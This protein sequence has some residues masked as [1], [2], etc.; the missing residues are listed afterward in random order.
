[1]ISLAPARCNSSLLPRRSICIRV[2]SRW[3]SEGVINFNPLDSRHDYVGP[4]WCS[5]LSIALAIL[6]AD[7]S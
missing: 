5:F 3:T 6:I 2:A 4:V 7:L 1:M